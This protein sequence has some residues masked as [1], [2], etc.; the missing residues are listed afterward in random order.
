MKIQTSQKKISPEFDFFVHSSLDRYEGK[1][2][3]ILGK[4]VVSSG[5]SAKTVWEKAREK[6][7]KSIPTIAKVPR[8]EI[9]VLIWK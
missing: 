8:Q 4:K 9:L 3:A 7:P 1:Y 2:V 5:L 6:Y